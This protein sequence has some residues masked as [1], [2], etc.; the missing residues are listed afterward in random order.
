APPAAPR[1][2]L[3]ESGAANSLEGSQTGR[4]GPDTP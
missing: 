3:A 1:S 4:S 2:A